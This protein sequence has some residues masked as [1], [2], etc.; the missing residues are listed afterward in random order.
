V[1]N[2]YSTPIILRD[3]GGAESA[4]HDGGIADVGGVIRARGG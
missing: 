2:I 1:D 3:I 4:G